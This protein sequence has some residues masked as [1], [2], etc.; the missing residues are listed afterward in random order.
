MFNAKD[1]NNRES[2]NKLLKYLKL[3]LNRI[4]GY[5]FIFKFLISILLKLSS[6]IKGLDSL[7]LLY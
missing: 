1:V 3:L 2:K 6:N 4:Q 5:F 7:K